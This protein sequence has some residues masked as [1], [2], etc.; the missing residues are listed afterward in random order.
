MNY[1]VSVPPGPGMTPMLG[2]SKR[3]QT[4]DSFRWMGASGGTPSVGGA[5]GGRGVWGEGLKN[6]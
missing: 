5:S 3:S 1:T 2:S 6:L 4:G